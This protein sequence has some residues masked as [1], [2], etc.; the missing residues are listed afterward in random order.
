[1]KKNDFKLIIGILLVA[2]VVFAWSHF[3]MQK[4]GG[5]AGVYVDGEASATYSLEQD[6][7]YEIE[8]D[9]GRNVLVIKDG[10]ADMT[11]A[12]C[13]DG[14]CVKRHSISKNGETIVC[15]PHKVVVE[16][17]SAEESGLDAVTQ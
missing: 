2:G 4:E 7:E 9:G 12:D 5:Q 8:T 10:E 1:M 15:L 6:G 3:V 14:L 16:V 17:I 11:E 13:P